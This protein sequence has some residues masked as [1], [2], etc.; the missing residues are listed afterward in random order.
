MTSTTQ[1]ITDFSSRAELLQDFC[2]ADHQRTLLIEESRQLAQRLQ[3]E[4]AKAIERLSSSVALNDDDD[5]DEEEENLKSQQKPF[6]N[7]SATPVRLTTA[8]T[9]TFN[10]PLEETNGRTQQQQQRSSKNN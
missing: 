9:L 1:I 7:D 10:S 6:L 5:D 3:T 2:S 8:D 4:I